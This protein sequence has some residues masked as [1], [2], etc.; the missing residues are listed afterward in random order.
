VAKRPLE[1][2]VSWLDIA[3]YTQSKFGVSFDVNLSFK[4]TIFGVEITTT[5]N[6]NANRNELVLEFD[7]FIETA[8]IASYDLQKFNS[9]VGRA[10]DSVISTTRWTTRVLDG[11]QER[12]SSIGSINAFINNKLLAPFQPVKFTENLLLDQYIQHTRIVEEEIY[13]LITEAQ[14]IL[15]VLTNLEDRLDVIHGIATR[16]DMHTTALKEEILSEL[17]TMVGGNRGKLNKMTRQLD[18]LKQ[19]GIYRRT[20][21]AHVSGTIVRLQAMSVGLEDLRE[22]VGSPELLRDRLDIPLSVHIEN[23][24][25]G[26]ERLE[27]SR[28]NARKVEDEH[29]RRTLERGRLE[30]TMIN[31]Q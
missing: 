6:S 29:I 4:S 9:H 20:A 23:I 14:A 19:I 5:G 17:W 10:V 26:V 18:L 7:G 8:R 3:N 12:D 2:S 24:E 27:E 30:G 21:Y 31:G 15:M 25:K 28:Q 11:I 1:T 13:K 16:D 22:R